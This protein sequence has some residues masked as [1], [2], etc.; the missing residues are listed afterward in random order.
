MSAL[1]EEL[2]AFKEGP[3]FRE[4]FGQRVSYK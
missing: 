4:L 2:L 3:Y 1:T